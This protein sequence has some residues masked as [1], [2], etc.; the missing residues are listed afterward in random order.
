MGDEELH[1]HMHAILAALRVL[2]S[3]AGPKVQADV[4]DALQALVVPPNGEL[5]LDDDVISAICGAQRE[6]G[7]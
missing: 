3:A 6:M 4:R 2:L 5:P 1:G 7:L